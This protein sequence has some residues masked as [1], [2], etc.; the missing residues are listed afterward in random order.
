MARKNKIGYTIPRIYLNKNFLHWEATMNTFLN[1]LEK[2]KTQFHLVDECKS[3]LADKGFEILDMANDWK[4]T[5]GKRYMVSPYSSMLVAFVYGACATSLRMAVAHTD[6]PM[7]KLKSKPEISKQGY[8]QA[9]VEPYGGLLTS[10]WFDRPLGLAG[11]VVTKGE[12]VFSPNVYLFDSEKAVFIIPNLAPHLK[13]DKGQEIDIQKELIP[14]SATAGSKEL[15]TE[16]Y[17]MNYVATNLSISTDDILDY[18]LYLYICDKPE[19]VGISDEFITSPRIDNISSVTGIMSALCSDH[20][21]NCI[22]VGTFFDNE[23]IGSRSKQGADSLLLRDILDRIVPEK[24]FYHN[25]FNLSIDVAHGTHPNYPEKSDITNQVILGNGVVLKTSA[26]QRYVTDSEA[27]AV[28]TALCQEKDIKLQKQVNRSGMPGGQT[29]GPIMSSYI[30]VKSV[31][32]GIPMLAMHSARELI[33]KED[34]TSLVN[35]VTKYYEY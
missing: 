9:N 14:I 8:L 3:F 10:T 28:V 15:S 23:E 24:S 5:P 27:G 34:Y 19:Y 2:G 30:P 13:K 11:K 33:H 20:I 22:A 26:S 12:N 35:L 16:A 17:I 21:E 25:A 6:F 7:L 18:D 32:I 29:L 4:L 1:F 31:D